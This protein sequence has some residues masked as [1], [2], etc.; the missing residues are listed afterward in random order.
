[1]VQLSRFGGVAREKR[2]AS[3]MPAASYIRIGGKV[4]FIEEHYFHIAI[5][6][7]QRDFFG[8]LFDPGNGGEGKVLI[9][10][11]ELSYQ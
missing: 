1:M 7:Q 8:D 6:L 10:V 5:S 9:A 11:L 4:R 2:L 3:L